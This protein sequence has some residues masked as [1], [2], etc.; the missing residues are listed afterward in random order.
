ML[1]SKNDDIVFIATHPFLFMDRKEVAR[2]IVECCRTH[3][4]MDL[5]FMTRAVTSVRTVILDGDGPYHSGTDCLYF[6]ADTV[7][8]DYSN[9][10][11]LVS[12]DI[13]HMLM[14]LILGHH[15]H[16]PDGCYDIAE[17]MIV[18]YALDMLNTAHISTEGRDGRVYLFDAMMQRIGTPTVDLM[19]G[20]IS[21]IS[22]YQIRTYI[23][24]YRRDDHS[25]RGDVTDNGW[26]DLS[27]QMLVEIEG[28]S[29][30]LE[31]RSEALLTVLRIRNRRKIDYRSF[32]R[33]FMTVRERVHID[34]S[35]FDP[36]YYTF[37]LETYGN[38]PLIEPVENSDVPAIEDFVIA[39]DTSGS[40]LERQVK[41]FVE[42][43]YDIMEQ[44]EMTTRTDLHIIQ[45]DDRVRSDTVIRSRADM[46]DLLSGMRILGGQGTDFRPVFEYVSE[47]VSEGKMENPKGLIY[48]TDGLGTYPHSRPPYPVAFI[49]CDDRYLDRDVPGWAMKVVIGSEDLKQRI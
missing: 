19:Y 10:P 6:H 49:F 25:K 26:K 21:K 2:E 38:I 20:E 28:F 44:C 13:A 46:R 1:S 8:D 14:H 43:V 15:V 34:P 33:R 3:I 22:E 31:G 40:T 29:R 48:F 9:D 27:E 12:R 23:G 32:L 30:N 11:N 35:E 18:E 36:I 7:I 16:N 24:A 41:G 17:D 47:L 42:D 39:I 45:C 5:R 4:C 37:G